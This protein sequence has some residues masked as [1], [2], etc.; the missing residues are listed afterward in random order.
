MLHPLTWPSVPKFCPLG[1]TTATNLTEDLCPE[2]SADILLL[3][4]DDPYQILYTIS[5][6]VSVPPGPRKLDITCCDIEPAVLARNI[7][8]FTMLEAGIPSTVVWEVF[9]HFRISTH[10]AGVLAAH[11]GELAAMSETCETWSLSKYGG[12]IKLVDSSSLSELRR[13]WIFYADFP[14]I[15]SLQLDKLENEQISRTS[16]LLNWLNGNGYYN[17]SR[18]ATVVRTD[19]W[20]SIS[21]HYGQYWKNGT[22]ATTSKEIKK[23]TH[24]NSTFCYSRAYGETFNGVPSITFP[25]SF[26]FAPAFVPIELDPVGSNV[27][28]AMAKAKQQ[29]KASCLALEASRKAGALTLR[30]FVGD[31]LALC[32]ALNMFTK[33][34]NPKTELFTAPWRAAPIDLTGHKAPG[35]QAPV[36]FDVID[37]STLANTLGI[38]NILL[39][40]QPLLKK[41]PESQAVVY[42]DLRFETRFTSK[43]FLH[44]LCSDVPKIGILLGLVPRPYVSLFTSRSNAHEL[45]PENQY[46]GFTERIAWVDPTSGD[47]SA[48][49]EPKPNVCLG[50]VDLLKT[51]FNL[52]QHMTLC[53]VL[54]LEKIL[55][56][57]HRKLQWTSSAHY[58]CETTVDLVVHLQPKI[59]LIL[60]DV[61]RTPASLQPL[62]TFFALEV[63]KKYP[64]AALNAEEMK[65]QCRF[66]NLFSDSEA[67]PQAPAPPSG[68]FQGWSNV[69]QQVCVVLT[70][71]REALDLLCQDREE[72]SP[73]LICTIR[74]VSED[75]QL[76]IFS[77][78][79]AAW[80]TCVPLNEPRDRF[81]IEEDPDGVRGR[82]NLVVSFWVDS[83]SLVH[84]DLRLSFALKYTPLTAINYCRKLDEELNLYATTIGDREHVLVLRERPMG[85]SGT[86]KSPTYPTP[87]PVDPKTS[88][89]H[90]IT[91]LDDRL[92]G[93]CYLIETRIELESE[94]EQAA[95]MTEA[96]VTSKQIGPCTLR[97]SVG[98]IERIVRFPY[99]IYGAQV[100]SRIDHKAHQIH[101]TTPPL[102][103]LQ[104]GGYPTDHFPLL[105]HANYSPWNLHHAHLDHMPKLDL[106]DVLRNPERFKW[107]QEHVLSQMS[108]RERFVRHCTN[109]VKRRSSDVLVSIKEAI[110]TIIQVY[111][112]LRQ[113]KQT[114]FALCESSHGIYM[115]I[116]VGGLRLD[117]SAAT[118]VLDTAVVAWSPE[119]EKLIGSETPIYEIQT[120]VHDVDVWKRLMAA[121]VERCRTWSHGPNCEYKSPGGAP[122]TGDI[123]DNPLCSCGQ[124]LGFDSG[125][126]K[127][128]AWK[129]L[130]LRSARAAIS[131][132]FGV[133]YLEDIFGPGLALQDAQQPISWDE[134]TDKCWQCGKTSGGLRG[135]HQCRKARYCSRDCQL[136]HWKSGHKR[137]C[138]SPTDLGGDAP[139]SLSV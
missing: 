32:K 64:Q 9:Y 73:R 53:D 42:T 61:S 1:S 92:Q 80:G 102:K 55:G 117:L 120:S 39:A 21:N 114:V 109:P 31:A 101:L 25:H 56:W 43:L 135:C 26:H 16:S 46:D 28:S 63:A 138:K 45:R 127:G 69:P 91:I 2:Q 77:C 7:I 33:T 6:G 107:L 62:V 72:V 93:P 41:Q 116:C 4:C 13:F 70:V 104:S 48:F 133:A 125:G 47:K 122:R 118:V 65:L 23:A 112:G 11:A 20:R 90:K 36:F 29:F 81:A 94:A 27:T 5:T 79:H 52:Q 84:P 126:W 12:F 68:V 113:P 99:P 3:G 110:T 130:L 60:D 76:S 87:P 136:M 67:A 30:F 66:R 103:A 14:N 40:T 124:G 89:W 97:V 51:M 10:V 15:S 50:G 123:G 121:C 78:I 129:D 86:Q 105:R 115:A 8:V 82:S 75:D 95:L 34:G 106:C 134:P 137:V 19:S 119:I 57:D 96:E 128:V 98:E 100:K 74:D 71:P 44:E 24:L 49:N 17:A 85:L 37:A 131:P 111:A 54:P 18:S 132:L 38:V 139:A 22:T 83:Q 35:L 58:T 108:D 88:I 59:S